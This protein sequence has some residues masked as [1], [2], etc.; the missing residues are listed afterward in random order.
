MRGLENTLQNSL[1][2]QIGSRQVFLAAS[3]R[4]GEELLLLDAWARNL[5]VE[6]PLLIVVPRHP[7]RFKEVAEM[8]QAK[9]LRIQ[10]RSENPIIDPQTEV[11]LGD[12]M[13]E[14]FA[15]HRL[16]DVAFIGGSLLNFGSQ[17]LIEACAVGTPVLLGPSTY[18]FSEAAHEAQAC[19]AAL[20]I[21]D[22]DDLV[23]KA[24]RL[25]KD[26]NARAQMSAAGLAFAQHHRGATTRTMEIIARSVE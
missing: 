10:R 24:L 7:Q 11:L 21:S 2:E 9:G 25:L 26:T 17:N 19:G 14:M 4:E 6:R 1:R 8:I 3:T 15:W 16:A 13:G 23:Q 12:S 20:A 5:P 22:A 18:N